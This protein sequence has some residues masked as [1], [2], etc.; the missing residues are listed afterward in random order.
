MKVLLAIL[1]FVCIAS[2]TDSLTCMIFQSAGCD[3]PSVNQT[4]PLNSCFFGMEYS[5]NGK[6][7]HIL[8]FA[9]MQCT[10]KPYMDLPVGALG[11]CDETNFPEV[12]YII[13]DLPQ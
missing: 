13:C 6:Q 4:L 12:P 2:A 9:D 3:G 7:I 11:Q 8:T 5:L 1:F 10:G